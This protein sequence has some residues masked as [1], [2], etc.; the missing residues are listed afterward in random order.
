MVE[1]FRPSTL[2]EALDLRA[3]GALPFGGGTDLMVARRGY[4][5]NLP[6]FDGALVF[7]DLIDE[8]RSIDKEGD[9]L[10]IGSAVTM[11]ELLDHPSTPDLL[12]EALLLIAAPGIRNR[13]TLGGNIGNASPAGDS[14][15]PLYLYDTQVELRSLTGTRTLPLKELISGVRRLTLGKDELITRILLPL[16]DFSFT[17]YRKVGTRRANA[18]SKLSFAGALALGDDGTIR[19]L[20]IALGAVAPTVVRK[21]NTEQTLLGIPLKTV[22]PDEAALKWTDVITPID[23]Q[24]STAAYRKQVALNL[25]AGFI[26]KAQEEL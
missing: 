17:R 25:I 20:R 9:T 22:N 6:R 13:A 11:T 16:T 2:E 23:D 26:R 1:T 15:V 18:L 12:R 7:T 5:G 10:K 21:E 14:L 3:R 8:L 4:A 24:R 19:D